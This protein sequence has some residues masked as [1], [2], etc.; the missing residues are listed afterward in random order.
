MISAA[1]FAALMTLRSGR[2]GLPLV[3]DT[4][5][6]TEGNAHQWVDTLTTLDYQ[7][8]QPFPKVVKVFRKRD[9]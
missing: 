5:I 3:G 7:S 9:E 2:R 8:G 4:V 1:L 6:E